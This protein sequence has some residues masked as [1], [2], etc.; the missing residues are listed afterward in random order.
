MTV[1]G[2]ARV[3]VGRQGI[4]DQH[5]S[6]LGYELRFA[7]VGTPADEASTGLTSA[8]VFGALSIGLDRLVGNKWI[9]CVAD[10]ETLIED[11]AI[12]LLPARSV[13]EV[14][15]QIEA[16]AEIIAGCRRLIA[17]GFT[18][19]VD[20]FDGSAGNDR[21]LDLAS[22]AKVDVQLHPEQTLRSLAD[23]CRQHFRRVVGKN[24]ETAEQLAKIRELGFDFYQGFALERPTQASGRMVSHGDIARTRLAS[25]LLGAEMDWG[26]IEDILRTE[27]GMT[28]QVMQLA[29]MGAIGETRRK[30]SSLRDALV[31]AGTWRI[32]AWV[33]LLL[34]QPTNPPSDG[35]VMTALV[36]ARAV[37]LLAMAHHDNAAEIGFAAG[38]LSSFEH[39]LQIPAE[40]L[41]RTLPL[42][43]D[44]REAAFGD[45]TPLGRIVCDVD[46]YLTGTNFPRLLSG[47]DRP[48]LDEAMASAFSWAA[49]VTASMD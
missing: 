11:S 36:R 35:G 24:I 18:I 41:Q 3:V 38:M 21:L 26:E 25:T 48:A 8:V 10:R 30:I 32:Q 13:I 4:Y 47:L 37:E 39:L 5:G 15:W 20:D 23:D 9:F 43:D 46:D 40:D 19:A 1:E 27:P 6:V 16:D 45:V 17:R 42:S 33:A 29:S 2:L 49:S 22:I 7:D 44:L 14:P 28:Y 31:L 34:A 12:S